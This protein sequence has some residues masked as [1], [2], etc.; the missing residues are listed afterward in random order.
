M[1]LHA[2][3]LEFL[4]TW[5]PKR[6]AKPG[7]ACVVTLATQL[8]LYI[9]SIIKSA[10]RFLGHGGGSKFGHSNYF[11]YW[12]SH[13]YTRRDKPSQ[14]HHHP[15][16]HQLLQQATIRTASIHYLI[17]VSILQSWCESLFLWNLSHRRHETEVC[18]CVCTFATMTMPVYWL[19]DHAHAAFSA[20]QS[21]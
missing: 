1:R 17:M 14:Q 4:G 15:P 19:Q 12:L 10:W 8:G 2:P 3:E 16:Q 20:D 6:A 11:G 7:F 5:P 21:L 9:P 18:V 13:C